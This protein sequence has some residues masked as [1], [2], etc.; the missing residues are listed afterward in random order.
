MSKYD[1][2]LSHNS[3]D[4]PA[5]EHLA[6]KLCEAGLQ[7]FL[8]KWHLIPGEP[9]QEAL[10]A[11]LDH[12]RTC[13]VF[14]GPGGLGSWENEEMR[15]AL[16]ERTQ[17]PGFRVIPVLL[18]DAQMPERG[19]L[20]RFLSRVVWVDFRPGLED[21]D[22]FHRLICG[23]KGIAPGPSEQLRSL[24]EEICPYRGL[25]PFDEQHTEFFFGREALTQWLVE[26]LR[27]SRFLAVIGPSG[28]GKSS[29][30]RA[31]LIPALR[32]GTLPGSE[33]WMILS[34][35]PGARPLE[36]LAAHLSRLPNGG[37]DR[38]TSMLQLQDRLH[39]DQRAL[40]AAVCLAL[41]DGPK[42][43]HVLLVADQFEE[44]FTLCQDEDER[45]RFLDNLLY[46][47]SIA[48]GR[49]LV[50]VALRADFYA[51]AATYLE[52]ADCMADHQVAVTPMVETELRQ[53]IEMPA[54]RVGL[55]FDVGLV[56]T[57]VEDVRGQPGMLPLLEHALLELWERR[58]DQQLTLQAYWKTGGVAGAVARR[59]ETEYER[60]SP[61]QQALTRRTLLRLVQPGEG[62]EDTRRCTYLSEL[63]F[64]SEQALQVRFVVQQLTSARLLTTS[65]DATSG[66]ELVDVAHEALI[67]GWPRL[68]GWIEENRAALRTHRRL[69]SAANEWKKKG[70]DESYLYRGAQ[71]AEAEEWWQAHLAEVNI[72]E[73]DFLKASTDL[74]DRESAA[75]DARSRRELETIHK[76]AE[77]E[78]M[79]TDSLESVGEI[80]QKISNTLNMDEVMAFVVERAIQLTEMD[81]GAVYLLSDEPTGPSVIR[82][83][84]FPE[85]HEHAI[86]RL[87]GGLGRN[88]ADVASGEIL[89]VRD[90]TRDGHID[91]MILSTGIRS[92]IAI[93][94]RLKE[95]IV[96]TLFLS[97]NQEHEFSE[98]EKSLLHTLAN[99]A[100]LAIEK[101]RLYESLQKSYED[102]EEAYNQ[103]RRLDQTKS[104]FMQN[105]THEIR[106]PLTFVSA[107][108]EL[109]R[110]GG[111]GHLSQEQQMAIDTVAAKVHLISRLMNDIISMQ[112]VDRRPLRLEVISLAKLGRA[113]L[114][115]AQPSAAE[116]DIT[117]SDEVLDELPPVL[118]DEQ[119][120][121]LVF[122]NL[123]H[124]ALKF[125]D[126]GSRV[127]VRMRE[128]GSMIRTE[129]EDQ[130]IGIPAD[131]LARVFGQFY[132]VDGSSTRR[133]GSTGLGLTIVKQ[134]VEA[135]G[136]QVEVESE[137][138]KGNLFYFTIPKAGCD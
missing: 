111:M 46:A 121:Y 31:G 3:A 102:L 17:T 54:Q 21:P 44:L 38:V 67:R 81:F 41:T 82:S 84:E 107:Y 9:L 45:Q 103:L 119:L 108:I 116:S 93:P 79:L 16:D 8:D 33:R 112:Q 7:P 74:R 56:D 118:G 88:W 80:S 99:Q 60:L 95:E 26:G 4:K 61:E 55:G 47:S 51:R 66:E 129:V 128:E 34:M 94:L 36:G 114:Q 64:S 90:V 115:A 86:S 5:V 71:L 92:L 11:A 39:K 14:V 62:T 109:L 28:S 20:P 87:S 132:Q 59:A 19:R 76:L 123:L 73:Q 18:P 69:T 29:V 24:A 27:N 75:A 105:I 2:F 136:G 12:S 72:L 89:A 15:V 50:V 85:D 101:V 1:V 110:D 49:T 43:S 63:L 30:V 126:A 127:T 134:I 23:I 124:N 57:I 122:D 13:A 70:W 135:H 125:S 98:E 35:T 131:K 138:G 48:L 106:A 91:P 96:A 100:A 6:Q 137:P 113:A 120:L 32:R 10:E 68:R 22:A 65:R 58:G 104:E 42:D 83:W 133:L 78:R 130:G 77:Y 37:E 52:L 40:H 97:S 25:Q 53:A 117:L